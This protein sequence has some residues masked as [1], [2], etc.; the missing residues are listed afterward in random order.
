MEKLPELVEESPG[1]V[2][3][4][5]TDM[6][7]VAELGEDAADAA[8][9]AIENIKKPYE[10]QLEMLDLQY[11]GATIENKGL[12]GGG[13]S[14]N[15]Q[16]SLLEQQYDI[17]KQIY[18]AILMDIMANSEPGSPEYE[19]AERHFRNFRTRWKALRPRL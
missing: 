17:Q 10:H 7:K 8:E 19:A 14:L 1:Y 18:E 9:E 2:E 16:V 4:F 13:V 12:V 5:G 11:A 15:E 3:Q 6:E